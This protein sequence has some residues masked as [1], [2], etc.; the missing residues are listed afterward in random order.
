[1]AVITHPYK[2]EDYL[3]LKKKKT[4]HCFDASNRISDAKSGFVFG[5][6]VN[7]HM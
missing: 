5:C 7:C 6:E 4:V 2:S 3:L 1:M